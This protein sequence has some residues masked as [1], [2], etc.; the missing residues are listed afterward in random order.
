MPNRGNSLWTE[1]TPDHVFRRLEGE[2]EVDVAIIGA[3]ITGV[4]AAP[5]LKDAGLKVALLD[6]TRVGTGETGKTTRLP[7]QMQRQ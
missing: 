6:A 1:T 4:T 7:L 5:I 2:I 3:G